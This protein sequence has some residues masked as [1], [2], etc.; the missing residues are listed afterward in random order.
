ML[1]SYSADVI[2]RMVVQYGKLGA[3]VSR[4]QFMS[5]VVALYSGNIL[6]SS[7]SSIST[8]GGLLYEDF[9]KYFIVVYMK[10]CHNW[11]TLNKDQR[12]LLKYLAGLDW[13]IGN[14]EGVHSTK[15][16]QTVK[17]VNTLKPFKTHNSV[18]GL[19]SDDDRYDANYDRDPAIVKQMRK[20]DRARGVT[21]RMQM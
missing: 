2:H 4:D 20:C 12:E 15:V 10:W 6:D 21:E 17:G 11:K 16:Q 13:N 5:E 3:C 7:N 19:M 8:W 18:S 14:M 9:K 1:S